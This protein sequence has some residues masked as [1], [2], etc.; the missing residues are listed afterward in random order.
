MTSMV[1]CLIPRVATMETEIG[2]VAGPPWRVLL[3]DDD[4]SFRRVLRVLLEDSPTF[5]VVGEAEDGA[6]AVDLA[7][8]LQPHSVILDMRM[9]VMDGDERAL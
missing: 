9:P 1:S 7:V 6:Q 5:A 8:A 2:Q 3:A 4:A